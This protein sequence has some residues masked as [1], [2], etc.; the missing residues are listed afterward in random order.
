MSELTSAF[1][2]AG[3]PYWWAARLGGAGW[4][5]FTGW[6]NIVGLIGIVASVGYGA[7]FFLN[8]VLAIYNVDIFG[9]NFAD[10]VHI[11]SETFL[12][13]LLILAF[14]SLVNIFSS[15]LLGLFNN[16]S[17]GWHVLGVAVIIAL[18]VFVPDSH[19]DAGFVFGER[20]NNTGFD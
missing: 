13:F 6:F 20:I 12:L 3:G 19:Q 11:L 18:L 1:P 15:H 2:T 4:S 9:I 14:I 7:A 10:D 17:V 8:A 16:V 5:W